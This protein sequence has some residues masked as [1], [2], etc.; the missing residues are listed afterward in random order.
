MHCRSIAVLLGVVTLVVAAGPKDESARPDRIGQKLDH[1]I[2]TDLDGKPTPLKGT[3]GRSA[4]IV[5]FLS[6]DCPV[7]N[8][9]VEPLKELARDQAERVAIIGVVPGDDPAAELKKKLGEFKVEF[10]IYRDPKGEAA[11][12]LKAKV[13]PEVFVLDADL[14]LRYR[15]RIDDAFTARMRRNPRQEKQDLRD[16]LDDVLAN[17]DVRTPVT[18]PIGCP[19][20]FPDTVVSAAGGV[21]YHRDVAPILQ[22]N[23][24]NCHRPGE[25]A[26]F[27]LLT[28]QQAAKWAGDIKDYT[29]SRQM[30]PW[31][32][33]G[34]PPYKG[35]RKLTDAEIAALAKWVDSGAP[36]GD[37]A[38]APPPVQYTEG[39]R[40]GPPDLIL[41]AS[42]PFH[43]GATG[44]DIF[45]CFVIPTGLTEN[46]WVVGFELR[47]GNPRV[48]HHTLNFFDTTGRARELD[49]RE[50]QRGREPEAKD[51]GPG[52]SV[53]MGVGFVPTPFTAGEVPKFGAM[54]GW[55]P[56]QAPQ[57]LPEGC[58]WLLPKEAD[59]IIQTH[60]H[61]DGRESDDRTQI[62]LYFAKKPV[63]QP[64]QTVVV[65]GMRGLTIIPA[66]KSDY[67]SK[68]AVYLNND[69][70]I[71]SVMPH[72][73]LIGKQ[74]KVTMTPPDGEPRVLVEIPHWDYN[75]Q[76][77]YWFREAIPAK[78]G[79][80]LEVEALY[81]NSAA[82]PNNPRNPPAPV[83]VGEQTTNEMLFAFVGVTSVKTPWERVRGRPT[84]PVPAQAK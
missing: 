17:R 71:H 45:R 82:N 30:P 9:Y 57:F 6:F 37:R 62:G 32:P 23:C 15:G 1:I 35:E 43:L 65:N 51:Y 29:Q 58:G 25:V 69:C 60:Y 56:G 66:G 3:P 10:P 53:A 18:E 13:T 44:P 31:M 68:G 77:T 16:A 48:V 75:W 52:Y 41:S 33:H 2:L 73:H 22:K 61:R 49:E 27:S 79:T 4:T 7:S 11:R 12:A 70:L 26:P 74:I 59:L 19:I 21:T 55:A 76:E 24:Q 78:S 81:D 54:G 83:F 67:V 46:K 34:G 63:A 20:S 47:P 72:M 80:K 36:E 8:S 28:Y 64:W 42:E 5:A 38:E 50:Q 39:W 40:N 84:P 14:R